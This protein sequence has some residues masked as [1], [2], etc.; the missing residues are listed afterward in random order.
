MDEVLVCL[1]GPVG[2]LTV[3]TLPFNP[4]WNLLVG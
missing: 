3:V 1:I 2:F 4:L